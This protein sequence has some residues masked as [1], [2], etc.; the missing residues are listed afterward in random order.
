MLQPLY[1]R[2]LQAKAVAR[3]KTK[4]KAEELDF[5]GDDEEVSEREDA[6]RTRAK[7]LKIKKAVKQAPDSKFLFTNSA[8]IGSLVISSTSTSKPAAISKAD[9]TQSSSLSKPKPQQKP[10]SS[11]DS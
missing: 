8:A 7:R 3:A 1:F 10:S 4:R 2:V 6:E 9:A 11:S 5:K